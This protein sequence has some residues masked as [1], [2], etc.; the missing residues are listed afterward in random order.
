M[1]G[2]KIEINVREESLGLRI[3]YIVTFILCFSAGTLVAETKPVR[4]ICS[5]E[6]TAWFAD[7]S[8]RRHTRVC[9][10]ASIEIPPF[11]YVIFEKINHDLFVYYG[12]SEGGPAFDMLVGKVSNIEEQQENFF[13]IDYYPCINLDKI[14]RSLYVEDLSLAVFSNKIANLLFYIDDDTLE[15]VEASDI[16]IY[17]TKYRQ[18]EPKKGLEYYESVV[19]DNNVYV[20]TE[21]N[22]DGEIISIC[23]EG[24]NIHL[25]A[26]SKNMQKID[27]YTDSWY[28]VELLD[29]KIGWIYGGYI[30]S[31]LKETVPVD[32]S[33]LI[34]GI[35][36]R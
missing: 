3:Y 2:Y 34:Y 36:E 21:P 1:D 30:Y 35:S 8:S 31:L 33:V 9:S 23:R 10:F 12:N 17:K 22:L 15:I 5:F 13:C 20:R 11:A 7:F 4:N 24:E 19:T 14:R 32:N 28:L 29:G 16:T 6:N 27:G 25:I 18:N 26:R